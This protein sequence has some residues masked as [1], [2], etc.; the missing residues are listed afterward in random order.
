MKI[1]LNYDII[2]EELK[3]L[4]KVKSAGIDK[5]EILSIGKSADEQ[6]KLLEYY[7]TLFTNLDYLVEGTIVFL[8]NAKDGFIE[9]EVAIVDAIKG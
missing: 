3:K 9:A 8:E 4:K 2:E 7:E 1:Q 5:M 6:V